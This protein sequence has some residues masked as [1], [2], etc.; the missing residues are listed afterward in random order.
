M[1]G[2]RDGF[3]F[4]KFKKK[5]FVNGNTLILCKTLNTFKT[6]LIIGGFTDKKWKYS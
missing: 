4:R 2:S 6:E 1:R 3:K 5:C